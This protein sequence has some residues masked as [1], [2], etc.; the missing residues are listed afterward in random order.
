VLKVSNVLDVSLDELFD[1]KPEKVKTGP[2]PKAL[3]IAERIS[4]LPKAK[5]SVLVGELHAQ[6]TNNHH[7]LLSLS[8]DLTLGSVFECDQRPMPTKDSAWRCDVCILL[9]ALST[10]PFPLLC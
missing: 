7:A 9:Q 5:Q 1:L 2:S 6:L 4:A 3:K 8:I 10:E